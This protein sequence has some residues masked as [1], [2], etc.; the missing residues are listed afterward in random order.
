VTESVEPRSDAAIPSATAAP[1]SSDPHHDLAG[2]LHDVSNAITVLLG[3]VA[4]ARSADATPE[5]VAYALSIIEQRARIARDLA[6]QAIGAPTDD[7]SRDLALVVADVGEALSLEAARAGVTLR[8]EGPARSGKVPGARDLSQVVTNLV[9]NA[10]A[11]APRG[12]AVNV[13]TGVDAAGCTIEVTD[14]GPGV[15]EDRREAIFLGHSTRSLGAGVG[16]RHSRALARVW[17]GDLRL[18][19][20]DAAVLPRTLDAE[21]RGAGAQF[22]VVWPCI[23]AVPRAPMSTARNLE[24]YSDLR[25]LLVEDDAAVSQLLESA[26][27]VRGADVTVVAKP[28]EFEEALLAG[29]FDVALVDLSPIEANPLAALARIRSAS[30]DVLLTLIT[31]NADALPEAVSELRLEWVRKPFEVQEVLAVLNRASAMKINA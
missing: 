15:P 20:D 25:V 22:E 26:L 1:L 29:V 13:R 17:G 7:E 11:F 12:T 2:V 18:V 27:A 5:S 16:L 8:V 10:L 21:G 24:D 14:E 3:W 30:P 23:D 9:L 28:T 19:V 4:E 6:R 31:G